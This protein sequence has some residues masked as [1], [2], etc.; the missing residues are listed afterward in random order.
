MNLPELILRTVERQPERVAL[1]GQGRSYTYGQ[2]WS[3]AGSL[4]RALRELG[5]RKGEKVFLL[6][7]N[8]PEWLICDLGVLRAGGVDVPRGSLSP[9]AELKELLHHSDST[10]LIAEGPEKLRALQELPPLK[11]VIL[12]EGEAP[13]A[14]ILEE[15]TNAVPPLE[16]PGPAEEGDLATILY[17]SGTTGRPKGAMLS[18]GNLV[19]NAKQALKTLSIYPED[20]L[21]AILPL[22][23]AF[24]RMV[25][26]AGLAAGARVFY[27]DL[28]RFL[29]DLRRVQPTVLAAVPRIWEAVRKRA[30]IPKVLLEAAFRWRQ[31]R[32]LPSL[33]LFLI[34][35]ALAFRRLR[36]ALGGRLRLAI[37]GGGS[38]PLEVD[39]FFMAC[40]LCLLNGYGLTEASPI[41]S[42]RTPERN[43]LGTVGR[44]LPDTQVKVEGTIKVKGPQ[45]MMGYYKDPEATSQVLQQGWLDTGDLGHI[46]PEGELVITGRAKDTI[47]LLGGENVEP[48]PIEERLRESPLIEDATVVGQDK[49]HLVALILPVEEVRHLPPRELEGMLHREVERLVNADPRFRPEERIVRFAILRQ[50]LF[51][52]RLEGEPLLTPT[53]K[54]R[55]FL[56]ER[57][58]RELID[59]L[60]R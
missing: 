2:L 30:R 29:Q 49:K 13:G 43:A 31:R 22:W 46:T 50:S 52:E 45:V 20:L 40:G 32:H 57:R 48:E 16:D 60:Y 34:G 15:L 44:P 26:Y 8:R 1:E 54:K 18:H 38:L 28:R 53:M 42:V 56:I 23:H 35:E 37:S 36:E 11:A 10:V 47:V 24:E 58:F 59:R 41:V 5:L 19:A 17:T 12:M 6:S 21:L 9:Q 25:E 51:E 7:D 33:P 55:R 39:R 14:V 3:K 27:T 4:A